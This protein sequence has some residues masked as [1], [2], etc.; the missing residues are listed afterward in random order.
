MRDPVSVKQKKALNMLTKTARIE[1]ASENISLITVYPRM[2]STDFAKNS[3]GN[4]Q[5]RQ[6]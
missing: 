2:I 3:I 1:L 5:L 4:Q 6:S